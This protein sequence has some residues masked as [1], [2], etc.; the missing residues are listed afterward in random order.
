MFV[1]VPRWYG[2]NR[3]CVICLLTA[4]EWARNPLYRR[5]NRNTEMKEAA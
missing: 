4:E 3:D 2:P 1:R 5:V